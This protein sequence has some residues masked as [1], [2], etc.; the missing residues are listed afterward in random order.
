MIELIIITKLIGEDDL[1][2]FFEV[3][4][5]NDIE[6]TISYKGERSKTS[7]NTGRI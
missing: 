2:N 3:I 5:Y 6:R 1:M 4:N 7:I